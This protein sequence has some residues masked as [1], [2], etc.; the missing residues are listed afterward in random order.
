M[1]GNVRLDRLLRHIENVKDGCIILAGRLL[2]NGE[3]EFAKQLIANGYVHDNSKFS[4]IEWEYLHDDMKESETEKFLLAAKQHVKT[5]QHHPEYWAG[6][7]NMPRIYVAEMVCDWRARSSEFGSDIW[8]WVKEKAMKK[9]DFSC[10]QKVYKEIKEFL[11]LL[12][13]KPFK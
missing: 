4:G 13:E 1:N 10:Q 2:E 8:E 3:D 12:L 11:S 5:N 6:I 7:E 9:F